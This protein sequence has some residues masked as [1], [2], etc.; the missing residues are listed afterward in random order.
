MPTLNFGAIEKEARQLR[1]AELQRIQDAFFAK[2]S[3][4][5]PLLVRAAHS[6][7]TAIGN[8]LRHLFSWNP[9]AH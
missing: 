6:A 1:N 2:V 3:A 8:G 4:Y 9:Q 5:I 7:L